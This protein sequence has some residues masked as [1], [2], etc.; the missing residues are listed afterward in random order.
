V[1]KVGKGL[2]RARKDESSSSNYLVVAEKRL[3]KT[4]LE[5]FVYKVRQV[6]EGTLNLQSS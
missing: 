3:N 1:Q 5:N 4:L 6:S 2:E